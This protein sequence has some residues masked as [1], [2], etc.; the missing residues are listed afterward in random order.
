VNETNETERGKGGTEEIRGGK[1]DAITKRK[2]DVMLEKN[3]R[4]I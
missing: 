4:K 2:K 1:E 3:E